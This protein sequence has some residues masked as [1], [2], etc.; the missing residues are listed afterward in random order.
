M[1]AGGVLAGV[2]GRGRTPEQAGLW[3]SECGGLVGEQHTQQGG[4]L[5]AM[6]EAGAFRTPSVMLSGSAGRLRVTLQAIDRRACAA[7]PH[8]VSEVITGRPIH[9]SYHGPVHCWNA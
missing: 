1:T 3:D 5:T 4:E 6:A 2:L 8:S 7:A 9:T